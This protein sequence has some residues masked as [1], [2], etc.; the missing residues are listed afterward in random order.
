MEAVAGKYFQREVVPLQPSFFINAASSG[1]LF[2][3]SK[4]ARTQNVAWWRGWRVRGRGIPGPRRFAS[5]LV[6]FVSAMP[7]AV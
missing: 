3:F 2:T 4:R 6:S 1:I 7:D 5:S